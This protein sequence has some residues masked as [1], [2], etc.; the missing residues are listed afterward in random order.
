MFLDRG[1]IMD[2]R[3]F[4][5]R[6]NPTCPLC[7]EEH[8]VY[9]ISISEAEQE[10]VDHYY[11]AHRS[12]PPFYLLMRAPPLSVKRNFRCPACGGRFSGYV[13]I[14]REGRHGY[15]SD[16]FIPMWREPVD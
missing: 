13:G 14:R 5:Y 10:Q 4:W 6:V 8:A 16:E 1:K 7:K 15:H 11:W 9:D 12:E 3:R 2:E